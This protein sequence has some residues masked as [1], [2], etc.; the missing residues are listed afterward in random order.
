MCQ[1]SLSLGGRVIVSLAQNFLG[2]FYYIHSLMKVKVILVGSFRF[3]SKTSRL[4]K[5]STITFERS[6]CIFELMNEVRT[7]VCVLF[8]AMKLQ[9]L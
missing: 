2:S 5:M 7:K 1:S 9:A 4:F 8:C 6:G 3:W